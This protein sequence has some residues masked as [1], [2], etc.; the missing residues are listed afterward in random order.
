MHGDFTVHKNIDKQYL[1]SI[2]R[3]TQPKERAECNERQSS[4]CSAELERQKVLDV[5]EDR[6][7]WNLLLSLRTNAEEKT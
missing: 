4:N 6:F 1:H 5:M 2:E 3:I 7:A